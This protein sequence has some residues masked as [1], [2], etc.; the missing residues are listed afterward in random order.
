MEAHDEA[1]Q[2][3]NRAYA[4]QDN[5]QCISYARRAIKAVPSTSALELLYKAH[6]DMGCPKRAMDY[7]FIEALLR[8]NDLGIW[9]ELLDFYKSMSNEANPLEKSRLID[10]ILGRI[11]TI[12]N[13][14]P[15][16]GPHG[17]KMDEIINLTLYRASLVTQIG[18]GTRAIRLYSRLLDNY[19]YHVEAYAEMA[20]LS[21]RLGNPTKALELLND[22]VANVGVGQ[23]ES[24]A[25][26]EDKSSPLVSPS[27][28]L[29][30]AS[31]R[32]EIQ[33]ETGSYMDAIT[34]IE[35]L[36]ETHG[37]DLC[38]TPA[39]F[40]R[41]IVAKV[42][43]ANTDATSFT[44]TLVECLE[45]TPL[46]SLLDSVDLLYDTANLFLRCNA[47]SLA[48][49]IF[50][51]LLEAR[52]THEGPEQST[53]IL[54]ALHLGIACCHRDMFDT[55]NVRPHLETVLQHDPFHVDALC[56]LAD[57]YISE[58][59]AGASGDE[60]MANSLISQNRDK[61]VDALTPKPETDAVLALRLLNQRARFY[62]HHDKANP[63]RFKLAEADLRVIVDAAMRDAPES[64]VIGGVLNAHG[65]HRRK[66]KGWT[67]TAQTLYPSSTLTMTQVLDGSTIG[68]SH[69]TDNFDSV[70]MA[71]QS[72]ADT[73]RWE[74]RPS[75]R[76]SGTKSHRFHTESLYSLG[77]ATQGPSQGSSTPSVIF[78]HFAK[79]SK[80]KKAAQ[81]G[82]TAADGDEAPVDDDFVS[83][84][85]SVGN[86]D[87]LDVFEGFLEENLSAKIDQ[88]GL[89][90]EIPEFD[91]EA[92]QDKAFQTADVVLHWLDVVIALQREEEILSTFF[93]FLS[94]LP[95]V[96]EQ[97]YWV[98]K[99][100]AARRITKPALRQ[101]IELYVLNK[102][103]L[104]GN[105]TMTAEQLTRLLRWQSHA[106]FGSA[107]V[108]SDS[109]KIWNAL[110]AL[111][112]STTLPFV[113]RRMIRNFLTQFRTAEAAHCIELTPESAVHIDRI[114]PFLTVLG[115]QSTQNM[116]RV[117]GQWSLVCY[118]RALSLKTNAALPLLCLATFY[119]RIC[120]HRKLP[121]RFVQS[122]EACWYFAL[123]HREEMQR[124]RGPIG[125]VEGTYNIGRIAQHVGLPHIATSCY[126]EV[127]RNQLICGVTIDDIDPAARKC[128]TL[129]QN[130]AYNLHT[131]YR[132][133][134]NYDLAFAV[135]MQHIRV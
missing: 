60:S 98:S 100:R 101:K 115:N 8:R 110:N 51:K 73:F 125:W 121:H 63:N 123:E 54:A 21:Y 113:N 80:D 59:Y 67:S 68:V 86:L 90:E 2:M 82:N 15:S 27:H 55:T 28:M 3:A 74:S 70:S 130:S 107:F 25:F 42:L 89:G 109:I 135:L 131:I 129:R 47:P 116:L 81:A 24:L 44:S 92:H 13:S 112:T 64:T 22:Y 65:A 5:N 33:N 61:I 56:M 48:R 120:R 40:A 127:L 114:L 93:L 9:Q 85:G 77:K 118:Y 34:G 19:P 20:T 4:M 1:M 124:E 106:E 71:S 66:R 50:E 30:I 119:A 36:I 53:V 23:A 83:T 76:P 45:K 134:G 14:Q 29:H 108:E 62:M 11:L 37:F 16:G 84:A 6:L 69:D 75:Q 32:A 10:Y 39:L 7:R 128:L 104:I 72:V 122:W 79:R 38:A 58:C 105:D 99:I 78:Q 103:I 97:F 52:S 95:D 12:L 57:H 31:I 117:A 26:A 43:L 18:E 132:Y 46:V 49:V 91:A 96:S 17:P 102:S 133:T 111:L 126:K 87:D 41:W 94:L 35:S 88:I